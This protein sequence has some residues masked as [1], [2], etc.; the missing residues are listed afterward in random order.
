MDSEDNLAQH[1]AKL[2]AAFPK[3]VVLRFIIIPV[4]LLY[5][6]TYASWSS[7]SNYLFDA[8]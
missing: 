3:D 4:M 5:T 7:G 1:Y 6:T 2:R 8:C